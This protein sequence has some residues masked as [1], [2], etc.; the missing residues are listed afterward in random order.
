MYKVYG[1]VIL[2]LDDPPIPSTIKSLPK[3]CW[4]HFNI[5]SAFAFYPLNGFR[6]FTIVAFIVFHLSL[7]GINW[8]LINNL[9]VCV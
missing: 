6:S 4:F 3:C 5:S 7:Y 9:C 1:N 8:Y 2:Y